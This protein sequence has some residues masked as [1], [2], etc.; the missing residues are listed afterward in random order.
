VAY[1]RRSAGLKALTIN[2]GAIGETGYVAEREGVQESL[3]RRGVHSVALKDSL[4]V[5]ELL[6]LHSEI[7]QVGL[8]PVN[9]K[10][11]AGVLA[12]LHSPQFS[13]LLKWDENYVDS[14]SSENK[15]G[16]LS[17]PLLQ[18]YSVA[19]AEE[20]PSLIK[21]YLQDKIGSMFG[22][23]PDDV[24]TSKRIIDLG[25]DS[26]MAIEIKNFV[27][28][29]LKA[30]I[31][32]LDLTGGKSIDELTVKI[33][34]QS[35]A[36]DVGTPSAVYKFAEF[37]CLRPVPEPTY[38]LICFPFMGGSSDVFRPWA[39]FLDPGVELWTPEPYDLGEWDPMLDKL[40][41]NIELIFKGDISTPLVIYGHSLGGLV[42]YEVALRLQN[43][44]PGKYPLVKALIIGASGP[45]TMPGIFH[46]I[47]EFSEE[48]VLRA[49]EDEEKFLKALV[50]L[51]IVENTHLHIK[52]LVQQVLFAMRHPKW[53][54]QLSRSQESEIFKGTLV[55][56][57]GTKDT[58][59]S[60][61]EVFHAWQK[62]TS[63]FHLHALDGT[64]SF[65][66]EKA[67]DVVKIVN[68]TF[69]G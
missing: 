39:E 64:H 10:V 53:Y 18:S 38:R 59:M 1:R 55:V 19:S 56:V 62:H 20:K 6:L 2:W 65:M 24:D 12:I 27:D 49:L 61:L 9:W 67:A 40:A 41:K 37:V 33:A 17:T 46:F 29:D 4:D 11:A 60:N 54:A 68:D 52:V 45:P 48:Q 36:T 5:L 66:I 8:A 42:A 13:H 44:T 50:Q 35:K 23:V 34:S 69:Y 32:V 30:E 28:K 7:P 51:G 22:V 57:H 15:S 25:V 47:T 31:S 3:L 63:Q 21:K 43:S 14:V 58:L 26:L 16:S